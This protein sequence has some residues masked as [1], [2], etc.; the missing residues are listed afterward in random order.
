M[1]HTTWQQP[2]TLLDQRAAWRFRVLTPEY[3]V[4]RTALVLPLQVPQD[5]VATGA[6]VQRLEAVLGHAVCAAG[7][8]RNAEAGAA[9][10]G[11]PLP[12]GTQKPEDNAPAYT[13]RSGIN[14]FRRTPQT[15]P[16]EAL[17]GDLTPARPDFWLWHR[18]I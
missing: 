13:R 12:S 11:A 7:P 9:G 3:P 5:W 16:R 1:S 14:P 10:H 2:L 4:L 17:T 6:R 8:S 15:V 18:G